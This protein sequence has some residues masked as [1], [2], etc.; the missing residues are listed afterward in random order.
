[1]RAHREFEWPDGYSHQSITE[2]NLFY[3]RY[4]KD[5]HNCWES[6]PRVRLEVM[7]AKEFLFAKDRPETSFPLK[8]TEYRKLYLDAANHALSWEP[9]TSESKVS[10]DGNTGVT[11]FDIK[12]T[13]DT[14]ITGYMKL[15]MWVTAEEYNDADIFINIQKLDTKGEWLPVSVLGEPHPGT[16]GKMRISHRALDEEKS[17]H[18]Q[19]IQSHLKE[20]KSS[21]VKSFPWMWNW[22]PSAASGTRGSR[23]VSR[24]PATISV[25]AG[26]SRSSGIPTTTATPRFTPA[27]ST[28]LTSRSLLS[29]PSL[30][31]AIFS[32]V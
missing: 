7:D 1:M 4:L 29:R 21:P 26:L 22:C 9:V 15:H 12:F 3:D 19:P 11:T 25:R 28:I 18:F 8:R 30:W 17:T 14:E 27:A 6:T 32:T 16:W 5:I 23:S 31:T 10:Y 20:E 24:S 2:L 13:E